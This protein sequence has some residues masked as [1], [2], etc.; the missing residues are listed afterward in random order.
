MITVFLLFEHQNLK[1]APLLKTEFLA[2]LLSPIGT[3]PKRQ[4]LT[5]MPTSIHTLWGPSKGGLWSPRTRLGRE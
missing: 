4:L 2:D 5:Q 1:A 3:S